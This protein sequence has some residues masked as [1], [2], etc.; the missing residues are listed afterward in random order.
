MQLQLTL[1]A[2]NDTVLYN[3]LRIFVYIPLRINVQIVPQVHIMAF[4]QVLRS[5]YDLFLTYENISLLERDI[6][7]VQ[8]KR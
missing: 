3:L 2:C 1:P 5:Y 8:L 4:Y 7:K 6:H